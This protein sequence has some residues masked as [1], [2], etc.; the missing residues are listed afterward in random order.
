MSKKITAGPLV[1][2]VKRLQ[3]EFPEAVYKRKSGKN[4]SYSSGTVSKGPKTHGCLVG[5]A[6]RNVYPDLFKIAK[7]EY[8]T[9][10][11]KEL[12]D[13]LNITATQNQIDYLETVQS[14]QDDRVCWGKCYR[15]ND[16]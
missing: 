10:G 16:E 15:L 8:D 4:C 12:L 9:Y 2:E 1:T 6:L 3:K 13:D 5:Q 11:V 14:N 7:K